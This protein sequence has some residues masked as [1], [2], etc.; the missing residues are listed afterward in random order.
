[1]FIPALG[2]LWDARLLELVASASSAV[3]LWSQS[4]L[5]EATDPVADLTERLRHPMLWR[6]AHPVKALRRAV[7]A[8]PV[9][10]P[11][12]RPEMELYYPPTFTLWAARV[13]GQFYTLSREEREALYKTWQT[14][15]C[16]TA[17]TLEDRAYVER[18]L[19]QV[20]HD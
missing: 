15:E 11:K 13:R 14:W 9:A 17:P 10:I 16:P 20:K 2:T 4:R 18:L 1:M 5:R 3:F 7:Q 19:G 12:K 8:P 6:M